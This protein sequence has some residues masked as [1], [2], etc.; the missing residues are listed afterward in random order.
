MLEMMD[1]QLDEVHLR[2]RGVRLVVEQCS[3]WSQK[4][5]SLI[6]RS[7]T[8]CDVG[9]GGGETHRMRYTNSIPLL[10]ANHN[11]FVTT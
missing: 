3:P 10:L 8:S 11:T 9:D 7:H 4:G 2:G 5:V 1:T 6:S